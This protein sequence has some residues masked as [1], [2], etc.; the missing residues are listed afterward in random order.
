MLF[1]SS[2]QHSFYPYTNL[3]GAPAHIVHAP[4][5]AGSDG[6]VFRDAIA[7]HWWPA[8]ERHRPDMIF[9]SAGFDAHREDPLGGLLLEDEDFAWVTREIRERAGGLC[10]GRIVSTLEGG[11]NVD[12]LARCVL[13]HLAELGGKPG[14]VS[15]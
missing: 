10:G 4:L 9:I 3:E 6:P 12:A 1:C 5:A 7:T 8:L 15:H 2:F 14:I 11:Y 13:R